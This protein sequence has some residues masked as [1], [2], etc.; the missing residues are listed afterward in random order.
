MTR[1]STCMALAVLAHAATL[2]PAVCAG[3][4]ARAAAHA[5]VAP[6]AV[7][8]GESLY[9]L[10]VTLA[11]ADGGTRELA[12]LRGRPVLIAMFYTS[13]QG[14]CPLLAFTMQRMEAA[15]TPEERARLQ[16]VMVSFDPERDTPQALSEFARLHQLDRSRWLLARTPAP[17]VRELAAVLGVRYRE[18]EDGTFSHSAVIT[19]LDA[20]GR[21]VERTTTLNTLDPAFLQALRR[22]LARDPRGP[23]P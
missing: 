9:Q 8:P 12:D 6:A 23:S 20:E 5:I 3:A 4:P 7:I 15:L 16:L 14:V 17:Q 21:I 10:D 22:A 2:A 13:C 11:T 1:M 18:T 19:L